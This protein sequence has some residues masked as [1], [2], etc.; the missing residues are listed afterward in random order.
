MYGIIF[1]FF[2]FVKI[3]NDNDFFYHIKW[4]MM[5]GE[6]EASNI[7]QHYLE[8]QKLVVRLLL[9]MVDIVAV[10]SIVVIDHYEDNHLMKVVDHSLDAL[11]AVLHVAVVDIDQLEDILVVEA[12]L[13]IDLAD[14][15]QPD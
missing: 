12:E 6:E 15:Y 10:D 5:W 9:L 1:G 14:H 11:M 8:L 2:A 3:E 13:D 4:I 7:H